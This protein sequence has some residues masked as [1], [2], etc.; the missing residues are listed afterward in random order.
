MGSEQRVPR[1]ALERQAEHQ[2]HELV[3]RGRSPEHEAATCPGEYGR[4]HWWRVR[5]GPGPA[6]HEAV[7]HMDVDQ[8]RELGIIAE[9][10]LRA[11]QREPGGSLDTLEA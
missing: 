7:M 5:H 2:Q 1:G 10:A 3:L 6:E 4:L 9:V 8:P 11:G